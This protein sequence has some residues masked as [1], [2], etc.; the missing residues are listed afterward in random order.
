[1]ATTGNGDGFRRRQE[2]KLDRAKTRAVKEE[3]LKDVRNSRSDRAANVL[4]APGSKKGP[5]SISTSTTDSRNSGNTSNINSTASKSGSEA[6]SSAGSTSRGGTGGIGGRS[7]AVVSGSGNSN[8]TNAVKKYKYG[9]MKKMNNGGSSATVMNSGNSSS[10]N[11]VNINSGNRTTKPGKSGAQLKKEG[12]AL[13]AKGT[14]MK[15]KGREL[16]AIGMTMNELGKLGTL[17]PKNYINDKILTSKKTGGA[18]K[19]MGAGGMH[20]MPDGSMMKN[21]M[22]KLGGMTNS[23]A[24]V[25]V[26]KVAKGRTG[27][28]SAAP[29]T[30]I[31]KGKYGMT[32]K[33][34]GMKKSC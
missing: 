16:K 11:R 8:S 9:G 15:N 3:I 20:M 14:N 27:G 6:A 28:T 32:M 13:K 33:K 23:N 24:K 18:I 17:G 12:M 21:S 31:P 4:S 34:G 5:K 1:M 25:V 19:K 29:K 30:A 7:N 10:S 22:M 26:S 2:R